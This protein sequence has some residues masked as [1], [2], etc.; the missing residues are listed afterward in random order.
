MANLHYNVDANRATIEALGGSLDD[1]ALTWGSVSEDEVD[2]DLFGE[3]NQFKIVLAADS[4]YDD[5]QPN[6]LAIALSEQL[7]FDSISRAV[8]MVPLRDEITKSLLRTFKAYMEAG[9]DVLSCL[10]EGTLDGQDDWGGGDDS[11]LITSHSETKEIK[12]HNMVGKP[13]YTRK[14]IEFVLIH[15]L[16]KSPPKKIV[17]AYTETFGQIVTIGQVKYL[18]NKYGRDPDYG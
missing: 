1:G 6:L 18:K 14:Q 4:I 8:V 10:E 11:S 13:S 3:K 7:S 5:I 17:E 12:W 2:Q 9:P 15:I 16:D